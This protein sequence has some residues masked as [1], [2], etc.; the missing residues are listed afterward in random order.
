VVCNGDAKVVNLTGEP[1]SKSIHAFC[2]KLQSWLQHISQINKA[3]LVNKEMAI[4]IIIPNILC[5]VLGEYLYDPMND[6]K[7]LPIR[8]ALIRGR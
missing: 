4:M 7:A 1:V 5:I 6:P 2:P 8:T 3:S